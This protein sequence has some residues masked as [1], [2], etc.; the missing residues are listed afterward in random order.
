[1]ETFRSINHTSTLA[2]PSSPPPSRGLRI[3]AAA[4]YIGNSPWFIGSSNPSEKKSLH[5]NLVV[6]TCCSRMTWTTT[7][8]VCALAVQHERYC[9][10]QRTFAGARLLEPIERRQHIQFIERRIAVQAICPMRHNAEAHQGDVACREFAQS[11]S[12][13]S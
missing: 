5:I 3:K 6:T 12:I 11:V 8:N 4:E 13:S 10:A 2:R 9:D 7:S 1:M